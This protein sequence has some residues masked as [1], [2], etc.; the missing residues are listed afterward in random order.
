VIKQNFLPKWAHRWPGPLCITFTAVLMLHWTWGSWPDPVIDF[1][2]ELYVPWQLTEGKVLYEDIF[3]FKGPLSPYLNSIL[4]RFFGVSLRTLVFGNL[5]VVILLLVLLY[6][7][8]SE[9]SD[10]VSATAA[11]ITFTAVFAFGNLMKEG[12]YNFICPYSHE[13]TH[14]MLFGLTSIWCMFMYLRRNSLLRVAAAGLALGLTFLTKAEVF[15]S[16][17][18]TF[19][20]FWALTIWSQRPERRLLVRLLAV[21]TISAIIPPFIAFLL[22]LFAMSPQQALLASAGP[23]QWIFNKNVSSGLFMSFY[24]WLMGLDRPLANF[25]KMFVWAGVFAAVFLPAGLLS[26]LLR[27]KGRHRI[28]IAAACFIIV[29]Y[30][31]GFASLRNPFP[32]LEAPRLLPLLMIVLIT[33]FFAALIL[34]RKDSNLHSRL[35]LQICFCAFALILLGKMLLFA[36]FYH[37]GFALAMP[38]ALLVVA[39]LTYYVPVL[40]DQ[41]GGLGAVFKAVGFAVLGVCILANLLITNFWLSKKTVRIDR[42]GDSFLTYQKGK[43]FN[44]LLRKLDEN[45]AADQTLAVFPEGIM[46]NYLARTPSTVPY[47]NYLPPTLFIIGEDKV[48]DSLKQNPPDWVVLIHRDSPEYGTRFFGVDY[49]RSLQRWITQNYEGKTCIGETP[50][51]S[52]KFGILIAKHKPVH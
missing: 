15:A 2:R 10:R 37:Y 6:R 31:L 35:I 28:A 5:A 49:A 29:V 42:S 26:F 27:R 11:C 52:E 20:L 19:V 39:A 44:I 24:N 14:A 46:V 32:W 23:W 41:K 21:F 18:L 3:Y 13:I 50:F 17:V 38:A 43:A 8:I 4:F 25:K 36:R 47:I 45:V 33:G 51:T 7:I 48:L 22:F 9:I 40:I 30:L 16:L 34:H 12:N 1:G